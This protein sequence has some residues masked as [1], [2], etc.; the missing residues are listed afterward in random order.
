M[1]HLPIHLPYEAKVGGPVQ[2]RWIYPFERFFKHLK[3]KVK[4]RALVEGSIC[5]AYII[6][7][8][9]SFCSLYFEPTVRTRLNRVSRNDDGGDVDSLGHLS[10][11]THLGRAFGLL[12]KSRFLNEDEFC[13]AK[14]YVL[15]NCEEMLPY[16]KCYKGYFVN[17]FKFHT[18]DYGENRKIMNSGVC[19]KG[20]FHND[21]ERDFYGI[22][23]DI[24]ELEYFGMGNRVVLFKCH[25]FDIEKGIKVDP[26]HGL[27]EIKYNSI[28]A[29]NEPFVLVAQAH[30]VYY[31][32]YPSTKRNR[33]DW[34]AIFKTKARSRFHIHSGGDRE[35]ETDLNE[36][37]YQ[38]A[39][40]TL[41]TSRPSEE[42]S[43]FI[44]LASGD[45]EEVNLLIADEEDDMQRYENEEDD[46]EGDENEDEDQIEDDDC[47]TFNDD[48]DNNE[49]HEFAY[50]ERAMVKGKHS[51]P[52]PRSTNA[53]GSISLPTNASTLAD[54]SIQQQMQQDYNDVSFETPSLL[55][56]SAEQV[57]NE[58]S[59]HDSRKSPSTDLGA[60]VD[61]TSSRP[62]GQEL[63]VGLRTP[64]DS[65]DRLR[66][67]LIGE[68]TFGFGF[69]VSL[70]IWALLCVTQ[71]AILDDR[72]N[73]I[74][75]LSSLRNQTAQVKKM[76]IKTNGGVKLYEAWWASH[77]VIG[78]MNV[79]EEEAGEK[80]KTLTLNLWA[81]NRE[82]KTNLSSG[83]EIMF[84][85][86]IV[87]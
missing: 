73:N 29:T 33:Y 6:E 35:N 82:P 79:E 67:T 83:H 70:A 54:I 76:K 50:S 45:Y 13:A 12:D 47:E 87:R 71:Q 86:E 52:R 44:V 38:E 58:T 57:H 60:S 81:S 40:S 19:I 22:L 69:F 9:S 85:T 75:V 78:T 25:Y 36:E 27:V 32:S 68:N 39:V 53:L 11:F 31:S 17:G 48:S 72:P 64:V 7:E 74:I 4:N 21:H 63:S 42:L 3:K 66:I 84:Q 16:I 46:M 23:V 49:E 65:S 28:L 18:L 37:V 26:L 15:M 2:Y 10:I 34:W 5:E 59:T 62:R 24:I 8:I 1:E 30:Q 56:A 77:A 55:G 80:Y 41:I 51:K 61:D 14:L 43:D 20:S